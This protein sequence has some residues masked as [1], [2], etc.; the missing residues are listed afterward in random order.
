M[1]G[2]ALPLQVV[3]DIP[4]YSKLYYGKPITLT[5]VPI[6]SLKVQMHDL[7]GRPMTFPRMESAGKGTMDF[8]FSLLPSV[9]NFSGWMMKLSSQVISFGSATFKPRFITLH[10]GLLQYHENELGLDTPRESILCKEVKRISYGPDNKSGHLTLHIHTSKTDWFL[11]WLEH[12]SDATKAR[13]IQTLELNCPH[14]AING[15]E[16]GRSTSVAGARTESVASSMS[17]SITLNSQK[18]AGKI[19]RRGSSLFAGSSHK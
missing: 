3:V 10:N 1:H 6:D 12:E 16:Q 13:W 14:V 8:S 5:R 15:D 7:A 9:R 11:H 18:S 17:N 19:L 4:Q 2:D